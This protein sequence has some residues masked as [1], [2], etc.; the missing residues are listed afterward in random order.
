MQTVPASEAKS[1]LGQWLERSLIEPVGITKS[2][3]RVAVL[4]SATEYDRLVETEEKALLARA[5]ESEKT[6]F[7]SEQETK[8]FLDSIINKT[9]QKSQI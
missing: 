4:I 9:E 3:R 5:L 7:L 2:G 6:G 8:E 1:R